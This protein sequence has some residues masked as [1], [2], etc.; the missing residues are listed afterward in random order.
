MSKPTAAEV[1]ASRKPRRTKVPIS[2]DGDL[3]EEIEDLKAQIRAAKR[4]EAADGGGLAAQSP[5]LEEQLRE[6]EA[7]RD[8]EA[9]EFVFEAMPRAEFKA[10]LTANQPTEEQWERYREQARVNPFV[11]APDCDF[12]AA[13]PIVISRCCISHDIDEAGAQEIWDAL[14]DGEAARL[15]DAAWGANQRVSQRPT[16]GTGTDMTPN[17]GP[18]ST[19]PPNGESPSQS[20]TDG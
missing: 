2:L 17:T 16:Y 15:F 13:A 9:H 3:D 18:D 19:T 12:D 7:R 4:Q 6:A 8:E 11:V 1:L 10:I 14:S 5:I 20:S